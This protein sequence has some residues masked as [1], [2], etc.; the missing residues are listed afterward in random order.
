MNSKKGSCGCG[1]L[2]YCVEGEPINSVFCYC[3]ECQVLTGSDKWFG[4]WFA[5]DSFKVTAGTP[6]IYTR[7]GDS[8]KDMNYL[9]CPQ[10]G[11]TIAAEVL[12]SRGC[13]ARESGWLGA[14]YGNLRCICAI[15]GGIP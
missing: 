9:F 11:G 12:F 14:P 10:C 13:N 6:S 5:K 3:K 1:N 8:G 2:R 7:A 4:A 15:L